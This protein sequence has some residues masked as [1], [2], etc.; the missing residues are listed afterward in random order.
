[1][2]I[3]IF[4]LEMG[5]RAVDFVKRLPLRYFFSQNA[6]ELV[7]QGTWFSYLWLP[8]QGNGHQDKVPKI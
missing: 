4:V 2:F 3:V 7:P 1:M 6:V 5:F 8:N